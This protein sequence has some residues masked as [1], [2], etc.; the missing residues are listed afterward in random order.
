M[1]NRTVEFVIVCLFN[2]VL[3]VICIT[4]QLRPTRLSEHSK[5]QLTNELKYLEHSSHLQ[6]KH[7]ASNKLLAGVNSQ[8][9]TSP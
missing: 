3:P 8:P 1:E 7:T 5:I 4:A 2:K 6:A 9:N